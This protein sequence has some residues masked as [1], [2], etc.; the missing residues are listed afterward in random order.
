M[1]RLRSCAPTDLEAD[2]GYLRG[3]AGARFAADDNDLIR[4]Q[5]PRDLVAPGADRQFF[6]IGDTKGGPANNGFRGAG[7]RVWVFRQTS[8]LLHKFT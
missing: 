2:L 3:L 6:R 5:N 1:F 4:A 8:G 7:T